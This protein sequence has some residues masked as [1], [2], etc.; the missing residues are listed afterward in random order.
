MKPNPRQSPGARNLRGRAKDRPGTVALPIATPTDTQRL[1]HKLQVQQIELEVQNEELQ[2]ARAELES[3]LERYTEVD[4]FAPAGYLTLQPDGVIRQANLTAARWLGMERSSLLKRRFVD[5]VATGNRLAFDALLQRAFASRALEIGEVTLANQGKPPFTF[6]LRA[7]VTGDGKE[8]RVALIDLTERQRAAAL[9]ASELFVRSILNSLTAH[10]AVLNAQGEIIAVNEAWRRFAQQ[11]GGAD[12]AAYI[13]VNYLAICEAGFQRDKDE[14]AKAAWSGL[15][16]VMSGAQAEFSLEYPCHS[17]NEQ[18]WFSLHA[19]AFRG[20]GPDRVV[21]AH[22]NFTPRKQAEE[23]LHGSRE[24]LRALAAHLETVREEERTH[25]AREIHDVLAQELTRLKMDVV[26]LH[27]RLAQP[28]TATQQTLLRERLTVMTAVTDTAIQS[29]QKIAT[30]LR[31]VVLDS[32]GLCA[33]V[34]WQA[35]DFQARTGIVC[36]ATVPEQDAPADRDRATAM[37]RVL[38]E[39][40]TNVLRHAQ[41]TRVEIRL[42]TEAGQMILRVQDNGGG[43]HPAKLHHPMSIGL[44]GMRERALLLHGQLEIQSPPGAGTT[45][46][47]RLPMVP[48]TKPPEAAP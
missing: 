31:P 9:G 29:V 27:R 25:V 36:V 20:E 32:L 37:F 39:S 3:A 46:E 4:M 23:E 11:N 19:T 35:R 16:A 38:Q 10:I 17:P 24:Q 41:A 13:G 15:R 12:P 8:C 22:E 43:I 2:R 42:R 5:F 26:W 7:S 28:L 1:L 48:P 30:E 21:V 34:D 18:R 44:A 33:A 40:L 14:S 45:I 47:M 6:Q